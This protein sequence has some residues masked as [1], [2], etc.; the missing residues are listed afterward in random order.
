[1]RAYKRL[2]ISIVCV[3]IGGANTLIGQENIEVERLKSIVLDKIKEDAVLQDSN[4]VLFNKEI[5]V[6]E[7]KMGNANTLELIDYSMFSQKNRFCYM[8]GYN[9]RFYIIASNKFDNNCRLDIFKSGG[10]DKVTTDLNSLK[11][12]FH[13]ELIDSSDDDKVTIYD[14]P[15]LLKEEFEIKFSLEHNKAGCAVLF[16][17]VS[18]LKN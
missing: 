1:M 3:L 2:L 17:V 12:Y 5:L 18:P 13:K 4:I 14:Y 8:K 6:N 11:V 16:V 7:K 9:I 15:L 10:F